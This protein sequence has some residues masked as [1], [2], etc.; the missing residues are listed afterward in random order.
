MAPAAMTGMPPPV[1]DDIDGTWTYLQGG[2]TQIMTN[3]QEGVDLKTY[4]GIY[5]FV[6]IAACSV[7]LTGSP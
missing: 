1:R 2:I 6:A 7:S 5:T 4:M 3:L